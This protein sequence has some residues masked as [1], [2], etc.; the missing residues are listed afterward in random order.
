MTMNNEKYVYAKSIAKN[1]IF[2]ENSQVFKCIAI[3]CNKQV[4]LA[5]NTQIDLFYAL[6]DELDKVTLNS[7][8]VEISPVLV[9]QKE[10][11]H[12][13]VRIEIEGKTYEGIVTDIFPIE[14]NKLLVTLQTNDKFVGVHINH[15]TPIKFLTTKK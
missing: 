15:Y 7:N 14:N 13:Q 5:A 8:F 11:I 10:T 1:A 4:N 12:K 9:L 3:I 2:D 6:L